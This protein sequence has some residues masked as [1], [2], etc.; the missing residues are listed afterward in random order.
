[1]L[2]TVGSMLTPLALRSRL[3]YPL[4]KKLNIALLGDSITAKTSSVYLNGADVEGIFYENESWFLYANSSLRQRFEYTHESNLGIGGNR[5]SDIIARLNELD[6]LDP[7]PEFV[8]DLSGTNDISAKVPAATIIA[9]RAIIH[10]YIINT[11]GAKVIALPILP[12][13]YWDGFTAGEIT[14]GKA[15]INT[16]NA[17]LASQASKDIIVVPDMYEALEGST[18]DEPETEYTTDGLHPSPTGA[19]V[20]GQELAKVL[21]PLVGAYSTQWARE[22]NQISNEYF[23]GTGG[24]GDTYSSGDVADG[25]EVSDRG[26]GSSSWRVFSKTPEGHQRIQIQAPQGNGNVGVWFTMDRPTLEVGS[27][28]YAELELD[29]VKT[30]GLFKTSLVLLDRSSDK[31]LRSHGT[32]DKQGE[33]LQPAYGNVVLRTPICTVMGTTDLEHQVYFDI[34][35]DSDAGAIDADIILKRVRLVKLPDP[36][37]LEGGGVLLKEDGS[38][39]LEEN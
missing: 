21:K 7:V 37:G 10:D 39:I 31:G 26:A 8:T 25:C 18:P 11:I 6:A 24:S 9:N 28:Y 4:S 16:V 33:R 32:M 13:S 17:W 14:Q 22:V 38:A 36:L 19:L 34:E 15:D 2:V 30:D 20:M 5:T 27:R 1:M 3:L 23:D 12:R 29:A 35:G